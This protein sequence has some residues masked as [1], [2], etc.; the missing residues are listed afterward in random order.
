[1]PSPTALKTTPLHEEHLT[2]GARM[3][4]F[5]GWE[6]PLQYDG[7]ISEY[8]YTRK[9]AAIFD[10]SHMGEYLLDG[11]CL[12]TGLDAI[13]TV[14]LKDMLLHTCRYGLMLNPHGGVLDDLIVIARVL[15]ESHAVREAGAT[16]GRDEH[17]QP[18]IGPT[19]PHQNA[20]QLGNREIAD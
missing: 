3:V 19:L 18:E 5:A 17:A 8:G 11:D 6:M 4:P 10:T 1:M 2:L 7:I 13:V 9:G 12:G 16:A 20:L 15:L 14:P